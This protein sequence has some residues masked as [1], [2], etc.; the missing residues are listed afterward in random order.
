M[1]NGGL[2]RWE[3]VVNGSEHKADLSPLYNIEVK[4][5]WMYTFTFTH[6]FIMHRFLT[7]YCILKR[8]WYLSVAVDKC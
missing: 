8:P 5:K 7:I 1:G 3:G 4:N 2:L 6:D